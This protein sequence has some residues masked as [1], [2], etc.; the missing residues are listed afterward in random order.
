MHW[1]FSAVEELL[2]VIVFFVGQQIAGFQVGLIAMVLL[3]LALLGAAHAFGRAAPRFALASTVALLVFSIPSI[4]TGDS[5]YF[6]VSDTVLDGFFAL[7]LLGS[8]VFGVPVLKFLFGQIFAITDEA[9]RILSLRWGFLFLVLAVL[10]EFIR[11]EYS[12]SVWATFKLVSTIFILLFG[13]YQ[14]TL[15]ARMRIPG[16]SNWLGLRR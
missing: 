14:F 2:P 1:L 5:S 7:L 13:C 16:E 9:W 15:S 8:V 6:Q 10:N 4:A 12:E 3:T 11:L